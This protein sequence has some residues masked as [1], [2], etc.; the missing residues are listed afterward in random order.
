MR[1]PMA[2]R[3]GTGGVFWWSATKS[4]GC[5]MLLSRALGPL[6]YLLGDRFACWIYPGFFK[7]NQAARDE[8]DIFHDL[9]WWLDL[10]KD[11]L[12]KI[13][14]QKTFLDVQVCQLVCLLYYFRLGRRQ[15]K[16]EQRWFRPLDGD[17]KQW[18]DE[19]PERPNLTKNS[20]NLLFHAWGA[21]LSP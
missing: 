20:L 10:R 17:S 21:C 2:S 18:S 8:V 16:W 12:E 14:L 1:L 15:Q 19:H 13:I 5:M 9:C 7:W 11:W 3:Y 6:V 4:E